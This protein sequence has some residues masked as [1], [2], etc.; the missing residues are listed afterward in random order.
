MKKIYVSAIFIALL[1]LVYNLGEQIEPP[2]FSTELSAP[3]SG[4]TPVK[5]YLQSRESQYNLRADNQARIVWADSVQKTN[6]VFL[7]LHGFSASQ[8]EGDPFHKKVAKHFEANLYLARLAGHGYQKNNLENFTAQAGWESAKEALALASQLGDTLVILSTSTG[9]TYALMLAQYFPE[10]VYGLVNLSPNVRVNSSAA[11]LLN[12]PWGQQ[13]GEWVLG[14]KR[15]IPY[16]SAAYPKYWDTTYTTQAVVELQNLLEFS[17]TEDNFKQMHTPCLN[18]FYYEN[19][20]NKDQVV[21]TQAIRWM[22]EE[23]GTPDSLK[24]LKPLTEPKNHVLGSPIKSE[25]VAVVVKT[26]LIF[27]ENI[28]KMKPKPKGARPSASKP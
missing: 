4:L 7:Y 18:V 9:C 13:I 2:Q 24:V 28:L 5:N 21:S 27:C 17:M 16:D 1:M 12:N 26:A 8:G 15:R 22:H 11:F 14:P 23:L 25:N 20:E 3:A 19:Q 6:Y 10:L